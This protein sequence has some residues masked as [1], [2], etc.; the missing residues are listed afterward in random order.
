MEMNKKYS[1]KQTATKMEIIS[2][3]KNILMHNSSC[4]LFNKEED[5]FSVSYNIDCE[6]FD[7]L[8]YIYTTGSQVLAC[9]SQ[10]AETPIE[11]HYF[12]ESSLIKIIKYLEHHGLTEENRPSEVEIKKKLTCDEAREIC[13]KAEYC[14]HYQVNAY[15]KQIAFIY[16]SK[17]YYAGKPNVKIVFPEVVR[18]GMQAGKIWALWG[19]YENVLFRML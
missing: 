11:L 8:N 1:K 19:K 3:I 5:K 16:E 15:Y 18:F 12:H 13:R 17:T 2:Y 6:C 9:F 4:V 10:E 7:S 14:L